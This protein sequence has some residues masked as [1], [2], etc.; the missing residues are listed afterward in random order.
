MRQQLMLNVENY[1]SNQTIFMSKLK[2]Q[3]LSSRPIVMCFH[4]TDS[5][6]TS[7][8]TFSCY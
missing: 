2:K 3:N 6:C 7:K 1:N 8:N 4:Y 5:H